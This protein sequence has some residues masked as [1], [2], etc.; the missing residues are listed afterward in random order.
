MTQRTSQQNKALHKYFALLATELNAAGFSVQLV[1]KEKMELDWNERSVKELL[2][3]SAQQALLG[4]QSTTDLDKQ[5][6]ITLV[7]EHLSRHLGEKFGVQVDFPSHEIGY[8]VTAPLIIH[9]HNA[10]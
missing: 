1:L 6:D 5:E 9:P 8:W 3:R 2:W 10:R 4:K 7:Y